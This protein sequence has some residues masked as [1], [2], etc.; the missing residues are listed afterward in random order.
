M[1]LIKSVAAALAFSA[2]IAGQALASETPTA[3]QLSGKQQSACGALL[4][5]AGAIMTGDLESECSGYAKE[6]FSILKFK[7][8]KFRASRTASARASFLNQC[9]SD[10]GGFKSKI[11]SKFGSLY[12]SPF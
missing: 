6:Y 2:A 7:R 4:C 10:D 5:L 1:T 9:P 8:G 3:P 12:A 11:G